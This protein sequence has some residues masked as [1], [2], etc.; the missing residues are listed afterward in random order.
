MNERL[1]RYSL[2]DR[3]WTYWGACWVL[4]SGRGDPALRTKA[5]EALTALSHGDPSDRLRRA[6]GAA[7][8]TL[9]PEEIRDLVARSGDREVDRA[10]VDP[11]GAA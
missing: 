11:Q 8:V 3:V 5:V 9:R 7:M 2:R 1:A 4:R 6:A 10:A